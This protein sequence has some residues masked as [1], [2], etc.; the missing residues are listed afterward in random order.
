VNKRAL[1]RL[2][3]IFVSLAVVLLGY[4]YYLKTR[5]VTQKV[6]T[7]QGTVTD[8]N[9]AHTGAPIGG[10]SD[11]YIKIGGKTIDYQL[12]DAVTDYNGVIQ[13]QGVEF[14][15]NIPQ[16]TKVSIKAFRLSRNEFTLD[17]TP[18]LYVK[19]LD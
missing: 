11:C 10:G 4:L 3:Y 14:G 13:V 19:S 12:T 15:G 1:R 5:P 6:V 18:G 2:S 17:K 7:F 9:C 8:S 16:G